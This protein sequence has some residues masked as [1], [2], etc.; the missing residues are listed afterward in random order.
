MSRIYVGSIAFDLNE[1]HIREVFAQ[2]GGVKS[3]T[4][5]V[6]P[7]TGKHKGYCFIEYDF[8][9]SAELALELM[10]GADLGGR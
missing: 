9:E 5:S 1:L 4:M 6:D 7:A 8:P 10:N 2:F 3:V